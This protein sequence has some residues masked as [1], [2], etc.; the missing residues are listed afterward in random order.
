MAQAKR[1]QVGAAARLEAPTSCS[2]DPYRPLHRHATGRDP[3]TAAHPQH[4]RRLGRS[5][6]R[7]DLPPC[8]R[9]ARGPQQ[10]QDP[11]KIAPRLL[12]HLRRWER[13][14]QGIRYIVNYQGK[15]ITKLNKAFR[16]CIAA[17][18]LSKDVTPHV[19]RHTRGTWL[20]QAGV[21]ANQAAASLGLTHEEYDRT[22]LHN[23][24][25]FQKEAAEAY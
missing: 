19:L 14:D 18:G 20:A 13:L 1:R 4:D 22:Y 6:A 16:S 15:P 17:A 21:P 7:C 2:R 9:R 10:T 3:E 8:R 24:P 5:G 11:V 23:D 12:A 25:T